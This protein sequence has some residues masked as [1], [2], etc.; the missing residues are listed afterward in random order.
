MPRVEIPEGAD[1]TMHV[2][3]NLAKPLTGPAAAL[4]GAVYS[5]S[6]L[7][8]RE[9][10]AARLRIAQINDCNICLNWRSARDVRDRADEADTIDEAF[11]AHVGDHEWTGFSERERLA[12]EFAERFALDHTEM[13]DD[14]WRRL[15]ASFTDDE[16]VELGICV[17][18]WLATGRFNRVFDIDGACRISL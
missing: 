11:Y 13:D 9:F 12:A 15:H 5:E 6:T 1:P 3:A 17:G 14:L 4:T 10:E 7:S 2:W 8:L 16:L 18:T